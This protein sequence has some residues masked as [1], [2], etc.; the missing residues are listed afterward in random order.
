MQRLA[1][2]SKKLDLQG[3]G[4][5]L[6]SKEQKIKSKKL[7]AEDQELE[8]QSLEMGAKKKVLLNK[9]QTI[10]T[11]DNF[12]FLKANKNTLEELT[13]TTVA[14]PVWTAVLSGGAIVAVPA[15]APIVVPIIV[16]FMGISYLVVTVLNF[17]KLK[18]SGSS[19][20]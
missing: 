18:F 2:E 16:A 20:K 9:I 7:D 13:A 3:E 19:S 6:Q 15:A 14:A 11:T 1:I 5:D 17:R 12:H 10:G 4:L 8:L